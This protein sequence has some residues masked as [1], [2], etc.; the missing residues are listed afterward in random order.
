MGMRS[1]FHHTLALLVVAAPTL[2]LIVLG[3]TAFAGRRVGPVAPGTPMAPPSH[4]R[5]ALELEHYQ[6]FDPASRSALAEAAD[7]CGGWMDHDLGE[8]GEP[9]DLTVSP[10]AAAEAGG[11]VLVIGAHWGADCPCPAELST[12]DGR[13]AEKELRFEGALDEPV[14]VRLA[15]GAPEATGSVTAVYL[16]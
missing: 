2:V 5:L 15:S 12:D 16:P 4:C 11:P 7:A 3:G 13:Q 1:R 6:P 9:V 8:P 10:G 14:T